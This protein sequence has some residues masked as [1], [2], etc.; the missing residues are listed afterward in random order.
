MP[1][2]EYSYPEAG[3][4]ETPTNTTNNCTVDPIL[5]ALLITFDQQ[6][7]LRWV[8]QTQVS[9]YHQEYGFAQ[10]QQMWTGQSK[11]QT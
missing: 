8:E 10:G 9:I 7:S 2:Q 11:T 1:V 3:V 5:P 6:S 4:L